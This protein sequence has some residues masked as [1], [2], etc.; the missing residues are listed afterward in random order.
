M[1]RHIT[2]LPI[3][4]ILITLLFSSCE[5]AQKSWRYQPP[6]EVK[7]ADVKNP[8]REQLVVA[9][10]VN[11]ITI[12]IVSE[13]PGA[14]RGEVILDAHEWDSHHYKNLM[15]KKLHSYWLDEIDDSMQFRSVIPGRT[16]YRAT[17]AADGGLK[18]VDLLAPSGITQYDMAARNSIDRRYPGLLTEFQPMPQDFRG[19]ELTVDIGFYVHNS[20][21]KETETEK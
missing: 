5:Q 1:L 11:V 14:Q 10:G 3:V 4:A 7:V 19:P 15:I 20:P 8:D 17:I 2:A 6:P 21:A 13:E 9:E 18:A 12:D 16:I